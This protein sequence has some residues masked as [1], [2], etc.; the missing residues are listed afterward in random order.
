MEDIQQ[1]R[2][3]LAYP[4]DIIVFSHRNP[5]GD[6]MGSSIGVK[7]YLEKLGHKV[8]IIFPSEFPSILTFLPALMT[9]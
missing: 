2:D 1:I 4:K 3:L 5:D 6:A 9:L 8:D 7:L